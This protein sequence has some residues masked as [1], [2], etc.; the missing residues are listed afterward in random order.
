MTILAIELGK[1]NSVLVWFEP[2]TRATAYRTI[3][4]TQPTFLEEPRIAGP[5]SFCLKSGGHESGS[6]G[7]A[8]R[9]AGPATGGTAGVDRSA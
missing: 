1:F 2:E 5:G 8:F 7:D 9:P 6:A 3:K 4:T